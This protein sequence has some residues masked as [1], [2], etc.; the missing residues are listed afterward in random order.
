MP[1][2]DD[3]IKTKSKKFEKKPYR[4]WDDMLTQDESLKTI[5]EKKPDEPIEKIELLVEVEEENLDRFSRGLY[6]VQRNVFRYIVINVIKKDDDFAYTKEI[7][8]HDLLDFV[9]APVPSIK[10]S[11]Q[12]LKKLGIMYH[13]EYKPGRGGYASYKIKL[14]KYSYFESYFKDD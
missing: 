13:H 2:I 10:V 12:R 4:P 11:L 9:K 1:H 7:T 8:I 14:D 5:N 6:G 3:L